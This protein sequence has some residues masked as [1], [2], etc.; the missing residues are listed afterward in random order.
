MPRDTPVWKVVVAALF[1][2]AALAVVA[3]GV[4]RMI[5]LTP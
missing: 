4:Y 5:Q 3:Y 2:V 1:A